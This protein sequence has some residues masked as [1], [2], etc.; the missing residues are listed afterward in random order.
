MGMCRN[1]VAQKIKYYKLN[2]NSDLS[3]S[4]I[5]HHLF[6]PIEALKVCTNLTHCSRSAGTDDVTE[7]PVMSPAPM[8][9]IGPSTSLLPTEEYGRLPPPYF[10]LHW[11][12]KGRPKKF[13]VSFNLKIL[14][15]FLRFEITRVRNNTSI[16]SPYT[17]PSPLYVFFVLHFFY[18]F[19][20]KILY[21]LCVSLAR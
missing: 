15:N 12:D 13:L 6:N 2:T 17:D 1:I 8:R 14:P 19:A 21:L 5:F 20:T 11:T 10:I 4:S 9:L 16:S 3:V 7:T 18:F